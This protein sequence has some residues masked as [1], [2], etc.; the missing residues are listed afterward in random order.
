MQVEIKLKKKGFIGIS[1]TLTPLP[2]EYIE[3]SPWNH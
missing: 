2:V 3:G 1:F